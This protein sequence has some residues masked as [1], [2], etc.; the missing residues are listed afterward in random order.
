MFSKTAI[1]APS[2]ALLIAVISIFV[3]LPAIQNDFVNWDDP[4]FVYENPDIR[5]IDF[6]SLKWMLTTYHT[7]DWF[8]LTWLSHAIDYA[9]WGLDP[10]GHHLTSIIF[11]GLNTFLAV[12]LII[13]L[14]NYAGNINQPS[15]ISENINRSP[16]TAIVAGAVTGLLFGLHPLHVES[17]AW[18]SERKD[19]LY[20]FFYILSILS[21]LKYASPELR[22]QKTLYYS[23]SLLFFIF[24]SMSKAMAVT[25]PVVLII[26]DVYPLERLD[27][28]SVFKRNHTVLAEKIPF[29]ALSI[30]LSIIT[31]LAN[32][33]E[34]AIAH[35]QIK[36]LGD[37]ILLA[38]RSLCFY[39][40]KMVWPADLV[41]LYPYPSGI[42][43]FSFQYM[44]SLVIL[45]C[46]TAICAIS[47]R[48]H[49]VFLTVWLYYIVTLL[50]VLGIIQSGSQAAADRYTYMSSL[51]PFLLAGLAA[52]LLL[53]KPII[54]SGNPVKKKAVILIMIVIPVILSS[55]TLSQLKLW[56][57][58]LTLWNKEI[59]V[60]PDGAYQA[61]YNRGKA[62]DE[63]GNFQMAISDYN[64]TIEL[65]P[66]FDDA[67][68][69]L[70]RA[71][72]ALGNH[73]YAIIIYNKAIELN[74][75]AE[76]AY[77][78][79]G[80]SYSK[81]G[82]YKQAIADCTTAVTLNPQYEKAYN[83]R[84]VFYGIIGDYQKS[85]DDLSKAIELDTLYTEAYY[86]RGVSYKNS[87]KYMQAIQD[88]NKVIQADPEHIRAYFERG[89]TYLK[90]GNYKKTDKDYISAARLGNKTA[91]EYLESK[92]IDW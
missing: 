44:G 71:H 22:K 57:N 10:A 55:L 79:R 61:Y 43:F 11:H 34:G 29:L 13:R 6:K 84:G 83:N 32:K 89:N 64:K 90:L 21:Y 91:R 17:V 77:Y 26:L 49:K 18:V 8:P 45:T 59:K 31:V 53:E 20:S 51:G 70:G 86:N 74:P 67:Y 19:V 66:V 85:I 27:F 58:S 87:K 35:F 76:D 30:A 60:Y 25:L 7:A 39:L 23:L 75:E 38:F 88:F 33:A 92:G 9:I 16:E 48:K 40:Y 69:N 63:K 28:R 52:A 62:L 50:P 12:I 81:S 15:I 41:P 36:F 14:I 65:N 80:V 46:I 1:K 72:D 2:V 5:A 37:R 73:Q 3:Y 68:V 24:S 54:R 56:K 78:N 4:S 42:Q 47:W 82:N